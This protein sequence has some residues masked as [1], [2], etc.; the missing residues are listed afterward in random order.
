M[1]DE[2]NSDH[3]NILFDLNLKKPSCA[4]KEIKFWKIK[5]IKMD[6]FKEDIKRVSDNSAKINEL[7]KLV[8]YYNNELKKILDD[9]AP[10]HERIIS[11]RKPTP[12]L[13]AD[14]KPEKPKRR[15]LEKKWRRTKLH[16][17]YDQFKKQRNKVNAML[18]TF[19]LK[20]YSDLIRKNANNPKALFKIL[21][22]ALHRKRDAST[23]S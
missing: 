10:E 13:S 14:I 2:H 23:S 9:H 8:N 3:N 15:R 11:L 16:V 12:W 1:V 21:D 18:N 19:R 4:K 5:A 7:D 20:Y 6:Q 17:D 22:R